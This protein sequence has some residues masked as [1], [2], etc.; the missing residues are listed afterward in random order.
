MLAPMIIASKSL[1]KKHHSTTISNLIR[2]ED[3]VIVTEGTRKCRNMSETDWLAKIAPKLRQ[4]RI[5][6]GTILA[7][8][9]IASK[10]ERKL[11]K[12]YFI[13]RAPFICAY[14]D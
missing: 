6:L 8:N 1:D 2:Q 3:S 5:F 11:Y 14:V 7:P 9:K 10:N 12:M 4:N 13:K